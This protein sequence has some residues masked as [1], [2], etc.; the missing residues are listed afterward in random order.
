MALVVPFY[1]WTSWPVVM[2][3]VYGVVDAARMQ[4]WNVVLMTA[5]D[6][7]SEIASAVRSKMVDRVAVMEVRIDDERLKLV[8]EI[9][10]PAVAIGL[11]SAQAKVP[12]VDFDFEAA[13]RLCVE[14]LVSLGHRHIG[15]LASPPEAFERKLA[16]AHRLWQGVAG[17]AER[18]G[19]VF[20]G[21][22][23]QPT[24]E[25][26]R[27]ALDGLFGQDPA[28]TALVVHSE[29][30]IDLVMHALEQRG[31][32]VPA[33]VSVIAVAWHEPIRRVA[34]SLTYVDVPAVEMGRTAVKLL[35]EGGTGILLPPALVAGG[36]VAPP[37]PS[38]TRARGA[39]VSRGQ[40]APAD[41]KQPGRA[42]RGPRATPGRTPESPGRESRW[43]QGT[44]FSRSDFERDTGR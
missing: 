34:A 37:P 19:L 11:P 32:S 43:Q 38:R 24:A 17:A 40:F 44:K 18:G 25:G 41:V 30:R 6:G 7:L 12:F 10:V 15:L 28:L 2:S 5:E 39:R 8:E 27:R 20:G 33:D 1:D 36:T 16:Y 14:H 29:G 31:K 35:A 13:G 23:L 42:S 9:R 26:A 22:P 4:G 3:F 21:L